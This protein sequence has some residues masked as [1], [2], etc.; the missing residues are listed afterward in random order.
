MNELQPIPQVAL[1]ILRL[2]DDEEYEIAQLTEEI[3]KDQV[4]SARTLK[5]CNSVM[6]SGKNKIE[7]LDHALVFLGMKLLVK[8]VISA[9]VEN[10]FTHSSAGYSLCKGGLYHHAIGTAIISEKLANLTGKA[11]PGLAYTAGLLHDIGK[12][13][14]D[15]HIASAYPLFYRQMFEEGNNFAEA[16][17][18]IL[19]VDHTGVG[20]ELAQK[21]SFPESLVETIRYHHR[22]QNS[23]QYHDLVHLVYLAD[24]LMSQFHAGLELERLETS[25]LAARL[26]AIGL[27]VERFPDIV[28]LIPIQVFDSAPEQAL[29][30]Q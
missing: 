27:S 17:K 22:P 3:R 5:L 7:T 23:G 4:I 14:L 21:W 11:K 18:R 8:L 29:M 1:K 12:V 13:V 25:T 30:Q 10:L 19:G 2:I 6:Y 28:D 9:S 26:E 16:E 15:Q 20:S 24:L